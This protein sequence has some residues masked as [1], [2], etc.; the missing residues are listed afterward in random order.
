MKL[1]VQNLACQ[2]IYFPKAEWAGLESLPEDSG[3]PGL[4]FVEQYTCG[5]SIL[6]LTLACTAGSDSLLME[7]FEAEKT[8][9]T[10]YSW[11]SRGCSAPPFCELQADAGAHCSHSAV[12]PASDCSLL[13]P[14]LPALPWQ[15]DTYRSTR[16]RDHVSIISSIF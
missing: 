5:I 11:Q 10:G 16:G 12:H 7:N 4:K 1:K 15:V 9:E 8:P 2:C 14:R 6:T 13:T 3:P